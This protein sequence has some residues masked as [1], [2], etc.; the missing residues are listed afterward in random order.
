LDLSFSIIFALIVARQVA[1][2]DEKFLENFPLFS[3]I[4]GEFSFL[5]A[6]A[7][8]ISVAKK[9]LTLFTLSRRYKAT[10]FLHEEVAKRDEELLMRVSHEYGN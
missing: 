6:Y 9:F 2:F 5:F 10:K 7:I 8:Y 4:V 1:L 3:R